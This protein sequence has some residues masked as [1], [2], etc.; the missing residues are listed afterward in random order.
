MMKVMLPLLLSCLIYERPGALNDNK[1]L[2]CN[3][4]FCKKQTFWITEFSSYLNVSKKTLFVFRACLLACRAKHPNKILS[5]L[6]I[7]LNISSRFI[8]IVDIEFK[9]IR[10]APLTAT[11]CTKFKAAYQPVYYDL[12]YSLRW[13]GEKKKIPAGFSSNQSCANSW[14][15]H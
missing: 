11:F 9:G 10:V 13:R 5:T 1:S 2:Y 12:Q 4:R 14:G 6:C 7:I 15:I 3:L 8:F